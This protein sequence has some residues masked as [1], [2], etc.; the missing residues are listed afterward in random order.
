MLTTLA[1]TRTKAKVCSVAIYGHSKAIQ[2]SKAYNPHPY[3]PEDSNLF[4]CVDKSVVT[5]KKRFISQAMTKE[6]MASVEPYIITHAQNFCHAVT[7]VSDVHSNDGSPQW[8][9]PRDMA[10]WSKLRVY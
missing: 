10:E 7:Q 9:G 8:A 6:V 2:K 4:A 3:Y 5:R 1:I